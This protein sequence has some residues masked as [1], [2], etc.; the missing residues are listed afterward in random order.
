MAPRNNETTPDTE[1][2]KTRFARRGGGGV[3][4]KK[5]V[6]TNPM[7]S[8]TFAGVQ[9]A[10]WSSPVISLVLTQCVGREGGSKKPI[11]PNPMIS[12]PQKHVCIMLL[13]ML[14]P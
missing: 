8:L 1:N 6:G 13:S 12:L 10:N 2:K 11:G 4:F 3:D 5:S 9:E 14:M 7:N